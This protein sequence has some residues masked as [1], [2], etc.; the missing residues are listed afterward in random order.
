M[1][2]TRNHNLKT[3]TT[4]AILLL[5]AAGPGVAS[6]STTAGKPAA[7]PSKGTAT[8]ATNSAPAAEVNVAGFDPVQAEVDRMQDLYRAV[9]N[10]HLLLQGDGVTSLTVSAALHDVERYLEEIDGKYATDQLFIKDQKALEQLT[11]IVAKAHFQGAILHARGV[12]LEASISQYEKTL[13]LLKSDPADWDQELER[14]ARPGLLPQAQEIAFQ[15]TTPREAVQDLKEFW[16]SGVVT[17]FKSRDLTPTQ[18]ATIQLERVG[19]RND[20]FSDA[21]FQ[22]AAQRFSQRIADALDEFRVVLPP[23]RYRVG[24]GDATFPPF[25]FQLQ[26]GGVPDPIYVNPNTF[27]FSWA[28]ENEKCR[29]TLVLNGLPVKTF[30][31]LPYGTYHVQRQPG[32]EQRLPDKISVDQNTEVTLRTEPPKLDFVREGQPIFLFI[33]TP[34]GSSY[35]LRF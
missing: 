32:C 3:L 14:T 33:T 35:T 1:N 7:K 8:Q 30:A 10:Y 26:E 4:A 21:S 27:S 20:A 22:V 11:K 17:R 12:D 6:S 31:G 24:S 18:R 23:G 5:A 25:D 2:E 13:D 16:A 34:P 28:S 29:P 15:L 9:T 19:G